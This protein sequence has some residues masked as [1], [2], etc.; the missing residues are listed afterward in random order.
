MKKKLLVIIS[1]AVVLLAGCDSSTTVTEIDTE[2]WTSDE[3]LSVEKTFDQQVE[4]FQYIKD[5]EDFLSYKVTSITE[6]KPYTSET[7]IDV[8]FDKSSSLHWWLEFSQKKYSKTNDF[9]TSNIE[10][11]LETNELEESSDPFETSWEISLLYQD[12]WMYLKVHDFDLFMWEE[13][14]NAKMLNLMWDLLKDKWVDLEINDWWF[15]SLDTESDEKLPYIIWTLKNVLK[16][17]WINEDSPNFLNGVANLIDVIN[18]HIDLW[19][20][21]NELKLLTQEDKYFQLSDW[22]IQRMFTWTFQW[23]ESEFSLSFTASKDW[24]KVSLYDIKE[25][26]AGLWYY[27]PTDSEFMLSI[28]ENKK[29]EYDVEIELLKSDIKIAEI[30]WELKYLDWVNLWL[31][32]VMEPLQL[33]AWQKISWKLE[34]SIVQNYWVDDSKFPTI[35]EET[36]LISEILSSIWI[37]LY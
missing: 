19:I 12:N 8:D 31:N 5:L 16:S 37:N 11:N 27:T 23:K 22:F 3:W 35:T 4:E 30:R 26:D 33:I 13:N 18:S 6:N 29:S 24:L 14:T 15:I 9:E 1:F 2:N 7:S 34:W 32:F 36:L 10:F 21:T 28:K 17:E 20:S 25:F